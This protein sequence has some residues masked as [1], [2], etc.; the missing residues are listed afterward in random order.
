MEVCRRPFA[1]DLFVVPQRRHFVVP[2]RKPFSI[3]NQGAAGLEYKCMESHLL[4]KRITSESDLT[5]GSI[6]D[7]V[8]RT[9]N[10]MLCVKEKTEESL[11]F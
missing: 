7:K 10:R 11:N 2:R 5:V 9:R 1:G 4:K 6:V 8:L 3:G